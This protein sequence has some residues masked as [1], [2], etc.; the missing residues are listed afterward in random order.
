MAA[1]ARLSGDR[2]NTAAILILQFAALAEAVA[3][4]RQA[5]QRAV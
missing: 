3:E 4:L 2:T 1:Y 5:Q